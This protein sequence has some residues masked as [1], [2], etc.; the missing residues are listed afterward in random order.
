MFFC[1]R[2]SAKV[3]L[4]AIPMIWLNNWG[5]THPPNQ[6]NSQPAHQLKK[7]EKNQAEI[8][9][10]SGEISKSHVV[11]KFLFLLLSGKSLEVLFD[12]LHM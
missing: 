8:P 10:N 11:S 2:L 5:H 4:S 1:G 6:T 7:K 3:P 12:F 9:R